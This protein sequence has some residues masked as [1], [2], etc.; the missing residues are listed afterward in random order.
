VK[1]EKMPKRN[2]STATPPEYPWSVPIT[3]AEVPETGRHVELVADE[4]T[5]QQIAKIANLRALPRLSATFDL[6]PHGR[7]GLRVTGRVA[8]L[9][10][11]DCVV[12]LEPVD[13][14]LDEAVDLV[15]VPPSI[16]VPDGSTAAMDIAADDPP[17][18]LVE[19]MV[20]LGIIAT[21]FL[22]LGIDPYPRKA[23]VVFDLPAAGDSGTSPFAALAALKPPRGREGS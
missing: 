4:R 11:Q 20:D 8:A 7:E 9:V 16:S 1:I 12:T 10:G 3:R 14:E 19:G 13:S 15:F 17:E 18:A 21:E 6:A 2:P 5:R 22:L 23:G